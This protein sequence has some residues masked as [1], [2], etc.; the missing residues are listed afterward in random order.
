MLIG[1]LKGLVSPMQNRVVSAS[2]FEAHVYIQHNYFNAQC[3]LMACIHTLRQ[4]YY[5]QIQN[6][7][8][9]RNCSSERLKLSQ[10]SFF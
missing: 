9:F 7:A 10:H 8:I 6:L 3:I 5:W 4:H 2:S 1:G